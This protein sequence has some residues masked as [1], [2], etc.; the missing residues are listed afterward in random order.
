[1]YVNADVAVQREPVNSPNTAVPLPH[2][3][4]CRCKSPLYLQGLRCH[5]AQ[6]FQLSQVKL[7]CILHLEFLWFQFVLWFSRCPCRCC[8]DCYAHWCAWWA[9]W[10]SVRMRHPVIPRTTT[11]LWNC[12]L[13]SLVEL[14]GHISGTLYELIIRM[15]FFYVK[16]YTIGSQFWTCHDSSAVV[17]WAKLWP[18]QMISTKNR[19]NLFSQ[20]LSYEYN[21]QW[22]GSQWQVIR[23]LSGP[24]YSCLFCP[25][26]Q[27]PHPS[28]VY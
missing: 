23:G 27:V 25:H 7:Q 10:Y 11:S 16:K 5:K 1:M 3:C 8:W 14:W 24:F 21:S 4:P 22:H 12:L 19:I 20:D 28:V 15:M 26:L 18:N 6:T 17:T 13:I 2:L 9:I